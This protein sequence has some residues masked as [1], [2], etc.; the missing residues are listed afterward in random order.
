MSLTFNLAVAKVPEVILFAFKLVTVIWLASIVP[1]V[2]LLADNEFIF[3]SV[4]ALSVI[5]GVV[6]ALFCISAVAVGASPIV[7]VKVAGDDSEPN[8]FN[9]VTLAT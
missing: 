5:K 7:K 8:T 6:I 2:I 3:A 4:T 9:E 1:A